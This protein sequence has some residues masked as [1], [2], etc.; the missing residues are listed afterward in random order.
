M[1]PSSSLR[2]QRPEVYVGIILVTVTA[3]EGHCYH[4]ATKY[5][6]IYVLEGAT[7]PEIYA[8]QLNNM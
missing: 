5:V 6:L 1:E 3:S 4:V 2:V 7:S 8:V